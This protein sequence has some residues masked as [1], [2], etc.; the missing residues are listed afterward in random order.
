[1]SVA[2]VA[3]G[4]YRIERVLGGGGMAVVYCARDEEL[5]RTVAVKLLA[6]HLTEDPEFRERFLGEARIAARLSHPNVVAVYDAGEDDGRPFIVME[7]VEGETLGDLFARCGRLP[8]NDV[9]HLGSQAAAGLAHAHAHGLVH[10]DVKPHN[11]LLR[12]DGVLKIADFGIARA[13][14]SATR[15]LT[16]AGTI[17]GTA[18][19]LAPEQASGGEVTAAADVYALGAVLYEALAGCAPFEGRTPFELLTA[20]QQDAV[21]PVSERVAGVPRALE[22]VVMRC[23]ARNPSYRPASAG[24]VERLLAGTGDAPTEPLA[25]RKPVLKGRGDVDVH[26]HQSSSDVDVHLHHLRFLAALA[27][28]LALAIAL[29]V[30]A[31]VATRGPSRPAAPPADSP[32]HPARQAGELAD[33]L[34][35]VAG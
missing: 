16:S 15:R 30:V 4:R 7:L 8:A 24:E 6:E 1:V 25:R 27:A 26:H 31:F 29:A 21:V 22:E 13:V 3:G 5:N 34:R 2:T 19:Y 28:V 35:A 11:L 9:V 12:T 33:W 18:A 14:A 23:L 10:R 32:N 20:R 17:L